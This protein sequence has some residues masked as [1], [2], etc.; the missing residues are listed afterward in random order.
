MT[1]FNIAKLI[2]D[3]ITMI[4]K[5]LSVVFVSR[6]P[7]SNSLRILN[8]CFR[9]HKDFP[10]QNLINGTAEDNKVYGRFLESVAPQMVC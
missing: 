8:D 10:A 7:M 1:H 2:L 6:I 3:M 9:A 5:S 4:T